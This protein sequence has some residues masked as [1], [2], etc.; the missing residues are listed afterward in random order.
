MFAVGASPHAA[1][2]ALPSVISHR[3]SHRSRSRRRSLLRLGPLALV[4][5]LFFILMRILV[6]VT[7][8]AA[9]GDR[10]ASEA[11]C[12]EEHFDP[13]H[14]IPAELHVAGVDGLPVDGRRAVRVGAQHSAERAAGAHRMAALGPA[15]RRGAAA[16]H[17]K[18]VRQREYHE[19]IC[20]VGCHGTVHEQR[21][22]RTQNL[23]RL[24]EARPPVTRH[25]EY[26]IHHFKQ[27]TDR[28]DQG[29]AERLH[30]AHGC[31]NLL[32]EAPDGPVLPMRH[33]AVHAAAS[34]VDPTVVRRDDAAPAVTAGGV[35]ETGDRRTVAVEADHAR[36]EL[37]HRQPIAADAGGSSR[38]QVP[39]HR[40]EVVVH[41]LPP[42]SHD[43]VSLPPVKARPRVDSTYSVPRFL[44]EN[45]CAHITCFRLAA[46]AAGSYACRARAGGSRVATG[47]GMP[48][49]RCARHGGGKSPATEGTLSEEPWGFG[50]PKK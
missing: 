38:V 43:R 41:R 20:E 34:R 27:L 5:I 49:R 48:V 22:P 18:P 50:F 46:R 29:H 26:H 9:V 45:R 24:L 7:V 14:R 35:E 25:Q 32:D 47:S 3:I 28:I 2:R 16:R 12:C 4:D 44:H 6:V 1:A 23:R 42:I 30:L 17:A 37:L 31:R 33:A 40:G 39:Q 36:A 19:S 13:V 8:A 10:R 21:L 11:H 15:Q